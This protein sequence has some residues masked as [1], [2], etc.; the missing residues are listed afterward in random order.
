M[1]DR[2]TCMA[3]AKAAAHR[4]T[5]QLRVQFAQLGPLGVKCVSGLDL[6]FCN[7]L[8]ALILERTKL[9]GGHAWAQE[10]GA[11]NRKAGPK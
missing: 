11:R 8:Y 10:G 4:T 5:T 1:S 6:G 9:A 2:E 7:D 3:A